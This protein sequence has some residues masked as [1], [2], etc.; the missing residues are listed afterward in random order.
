AAGTAG[1]SARLAITAASAPI[2]S[3]R[4]LRTVQLS[5]ATGRCRNQSARDLHD[6]LHPGVRRAVVGVLARGREDVLPALAVL[7]HPG[8]ERV[9][10]GRDRVALVPGVR[11]VDRLTN[12]DGDG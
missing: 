8:V 3:R 1:A 9:V 12:L 10:V 4:P 7:L 2:T 11:P 5:P 6:A